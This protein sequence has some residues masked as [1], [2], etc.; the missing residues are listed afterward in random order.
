MIYRLFVF[1][2]CGYVDVVKACVDNSVDFSIALKGMKR[3]FCF[4][5]DLVYSILKSYISYCDFL[6]GGDVI[7]WLKMVEKKPI[8]PQ[9]GRKW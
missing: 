7:K 1:S 6:E 2:K 4:Y 3:C 5:A 8:Y 9:S